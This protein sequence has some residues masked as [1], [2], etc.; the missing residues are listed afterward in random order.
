MA[1]NEC[2]SISGEKCLY[3]LTRLHLDTDTNRPAEWWEGLMALMFEIFSA[4]ACASMLPL[5]CSHAASAA[6]D[7][8]IP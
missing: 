5:S 6:V 4:L 3:P 7:Q 8:S 1:D 2:M